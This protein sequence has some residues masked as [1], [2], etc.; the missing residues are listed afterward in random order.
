MRIVAAEVLR[1]GDADAGRALL[2]AAHDRRVGPAMIGGDGEVE[3][4]AMPD[5][6]TPVGDAPS[7]EDLA[8][9]FTESAVEEASASVTPLP[10][11]GKGRAARG[12]TRRRTSK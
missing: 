9:A 5:D 3:P 6:G 10:A 1:D 12:G 7:V 8:P 4:A 11:K 2:R